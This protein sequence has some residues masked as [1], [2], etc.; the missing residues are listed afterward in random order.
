MPRRDIT[1]VERLAL[2]E[3]I[4]KTTPNTYL[5]QLAEINGIPKLHK[6]QLQDSVFEGDKYG[7]FTSSV[8]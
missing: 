4:K 5:R 3:K 8:L 2:V 1:L 7:Q 6:L